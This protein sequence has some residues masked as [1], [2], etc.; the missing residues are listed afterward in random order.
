MIRDKK[1]RRHNSPIVIDLDGPEGNAFQLLAYAT[2]WCKDIGI[3]YK[4]FQK[5]AT[6]GDYENLL[7]VFDKYFGKYVIFERTPLEKNNASND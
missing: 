6:S 2:K 5:E 7:K 3:D 1:P 4:E